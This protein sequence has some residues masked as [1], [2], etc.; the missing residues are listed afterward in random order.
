[1]SRIEWDDALSVKNDEIDDQHKK[2]I[3]IHN[4]LHE[5]LL[6]GNMDDVNKIGVE[7]LQEMQEYAHYHFNF[8]EEYMEKINYPGI[9]EHRRLH[10]DFD[11]RIYNTNREVQD[12]QV[13]LN[14]A[15]LKVLKS[16][17]LEHI[18]HEDQKYCR[19]LQDT[20]SGV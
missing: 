1:M 4:R 18:L 7:T 14:S 19:F 2:W 20:S 11:T 8:E 5:V 9:V 13:V 16:W 6:S 10:K 15:I 3:E 12:G 17:L